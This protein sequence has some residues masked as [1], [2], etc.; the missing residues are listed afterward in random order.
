LINKKNIKKEY[1]LS[2]NDTIT[3]YPNT[4]IEYDILD[5]KTKIMVL[6]DKTFNESI[7]IHDFQSFLTLE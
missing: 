6:A 7:V 4:W 5:T 1:F 2:K 3:I